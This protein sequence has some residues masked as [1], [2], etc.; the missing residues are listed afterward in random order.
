VLLAALTA[1]SALA[2]AGPAEEKRAGELFDKAE[3]EYQAGRFAEAVELL[4]EAQRLAP[5][6]VLHYNLAR[7]YEGMGKLDEALASYRAYVEGDPTSKDRGAVE[8]R[9]KTIEELRDARAKAAAEPARRDPAVEPKTPIVEARSPSPG[10]WIV[11]GVGVLGFGAAGALGGLYLSKKS[12]AEDPAT[13]GRDALAAQS[14]AQTF[15]T[16]ANIA[17]PI[18]GVVAGV[19]LIWGIVDV[20]SLDEPSDEGARVS[21]RIGP[22]GASLT[23]SF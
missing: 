19:G 10:P 16:G 11:L 7:A 22:A 14:D 5:D 8:A 17:F 4:L 6:P 1:T 21:L 15:A 13:S 18:A 23:G 20:V 3:T 9:I 12:E 2:H